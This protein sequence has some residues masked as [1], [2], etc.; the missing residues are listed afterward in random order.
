MHTEI[1]DNNQVELLPYIKNFQRSFYMVGGTAI[2]LYL[3]H[4]RSIDFD[5]FSHSTLIKHRIKR[6]LLEIPFKQVPIFEDYNQLHLQINKIKVTFFHFPYLVNHPV[7]VD[8]FITIPTLL[9]LAAMKAFALGRRAKWKDYV[10]LF[11]ILK[12][13]FTIQEI[14]RESES[15][16][17][18]QFS[19]KLF[20][21]QLSFHKDIDHSEPIEYLVPAVPEDEIK[22]YLIDI[23][24]DIGL[25]GN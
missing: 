1:L 25:F 17:G 4:R 23:A 7:K 11:F 8:S 21:E 24:T 2:A 9:S 16:F 22:S 12:Y 13:H 10:D 14:C 15:I 19:G 20:R 3:G 5:L 18:S 6:K